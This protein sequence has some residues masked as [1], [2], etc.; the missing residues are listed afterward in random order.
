MAGTDTGFRVW[1]GGHADV[2]GWGHNTSVQMHHL[3]I[4]SCFGCAFSLPVFRSPQLHS[5]LMS[6]NCFIIDVME[7]KTAAHSFYS[8]LQRMT[9]SGFPSSLPVSNKI[10]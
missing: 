3:L 10:C 5:H 9:N 1:S 4:S 2:I 7:S 6:S 8:K